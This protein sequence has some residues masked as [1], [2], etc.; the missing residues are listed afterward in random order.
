MS[1]QVG[2]PPRVASQTPDRHS[3]WIRRTTSIDQRQTANPPSLRSAARAATRG[4][5]PTSVALV[6]AILVLP[7]L[8]FAADAPTTDAARFEVV[9]VY[10]DSG[11]HPLAA[12]QVELKAIQGDVKI[13]GIEGGDHRDLYRDPPYYDPKALTTGH[14]I[15]LASYTTANTAPKGK[16][17]V[18][19]VHL[20][21]IG[22]YRLSI[23]PMAA[24]D[25]T[26]QSIATTA[27]VANAP[28]T[29][30]AKDKE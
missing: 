28:T 8:S 19:R 7:L 22:E 18:A 16:T 10:I 24:A 12:W 23:T 30:T 17:L 27:S 3:W 5:W 14:R 13:V 11:D 1:H 21:I 15:I 25:P 20:R 2:H 26:G 29:T 9:N 4:G 6:L